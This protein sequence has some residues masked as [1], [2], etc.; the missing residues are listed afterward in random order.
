MGR[1]LE[2]TVTT[3]VNASVDRVWKVW[4]NLEAMPRWMR[5][6]ESVNLIDDDPNLTNWTLAAQGFRFNWKARI[7]QR[8]EAQQLHWESIGGLPTK[9]TV[10]F[11]AE[12]DNI[13][14]VKLT[15]S[16]QLPGALAPL[17][18]DRILGGIVV[19]ELQSNLNRFRDL[20][21]TD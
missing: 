11:Y 2:H 5:W 17:M 16:Y 14:S 10:R 6:I 12:S 8:V 4:S 13:T 7:I 9:G 3:K 18:E 20:V 21:Q 1:W 19:K 15:V